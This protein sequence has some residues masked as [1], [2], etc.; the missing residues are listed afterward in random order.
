MPVLHHSWPGCGRHWCL[1]HSFCQLSSCLAFHRI[2][3]LRNLRPL[4]LLDLP[5][6]S[7]NSFPLSLLPRQTF[8]ATLFT[9]S[10]RQLVRFRPILHMDFGL[11]LCAE[12]ASGKPLYKVFA[13]F[14]AVDRVAHLAPPQI[15]FSISSHAS[16]VM[17]LPQ[18]GQYFWF[19]RRPALYPHFEHLYFFHFSASRTLYGLWLHS[20]SSSHSAVHASQSM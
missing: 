3:K 13:F 4:C 11:I 1:A 8:F 19:T 17:A 6:N 5:Y 18:D 12:P 15:L 9:L 10:E 16:G 14:R 7:S 20:P 2:N